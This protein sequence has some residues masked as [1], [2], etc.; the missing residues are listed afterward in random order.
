M[1]RK[2]IILLMIVT[3]LTSFIF[4][5]PLITP[6]SGLS[7]NTPLEISGIWNPNKN[8][9]FILSANYQ[10]IDYEQ[11]SI[12]YQTE[13]YNLANSGQTE[14]F[15]L[16]T[17]SNFSSSGWIFRKNYELNIYYSEIFHPVEDTLYDAGI[18]NYP[19]ISISLNYNLSQSEFGFWI[20]TTKYIAADQSVQNQSTTMNYGVNRT[21]NARRYKFDIAIPSGMQALDLINFNFGWDGYT[22]SVS[23]LWDMEGYVKVVIV[24]N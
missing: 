11:N 24:S 20:F 13:D 21:V 12:Q 14:S 19:N 5:D 10:G 15:N 23:Q 4:A 22:N 8:P 16:Y 2:K 3:V 7:L 18:A 6:I 1:K 9:I 17:Y